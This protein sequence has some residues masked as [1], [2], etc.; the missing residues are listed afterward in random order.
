MQARRLRYVSAQLAGG[1]C[2]PCAA[3]A[4]LMLELPD[5]A[6]DNNNMDD[7]SVIEFKHHCLEII[8]RSRAAKIWK[9]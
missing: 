2:A 7:I 9:P 4:C 1:S 3:T 8:R 5:R 6:I